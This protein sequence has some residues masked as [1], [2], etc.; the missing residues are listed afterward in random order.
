LIKNSFLIKC[1]HISGVIGFTVSI[2]TCGKIA[3]FYIKENMEQ[4]IRY[5]DVVV[6][7]AG[8]GGLTAGAILAKEGLDVVICESNTQAGGYLAGFCRGGFQF[9][10]SIQW[11]NQAIPGGILF[12]LWEYLG[13][14]APKCHS[15][16][17]IHRWVGPEHDYILTSNPIE[18]RDE[19]IKEFP[20]DKK[21]IL[22]FFKDAKKMAVHLKV[23]N[24]LMRT[25][26]NLSFFGKI[27]RGLIM[28]RHGL[29]MVPYIK[30]P[31]EKLLK[32]YFSTPK[33]RGIF[34]S[35]ESFAAV[36]FPVAC[37]FCDDFQAAPEGG[38][39]TIASWLS[40]VV[41]ENNG[42]V[43]L[44]IKV[45]K[46]LVNNSNTAY[47]VAL[48]DGTEIR[49]KYVI[50]AC[51]LFNLYKYML[52]MGAVAE[53]KIE[54]IGQADMYKSSFT[55]FLG[56]DCI[57][58]ELGFGEEVLHIVTDNPHRIDHASS[59]PYKTIIMV[60]AQSVR[61]KT[62]APE[63]KGTLMIHCPASME[64]GNYWKTSPKGVRGEDYNAFKEEFA[65]VL[66][67]RV[68]ARLAPDLKQHIV[69][70][71]IA[72]PLTYER[73]SLNYLGTIMGVKPNKA[74]IK[75]GLAHMKTPV[76]NL[77]IGG[78]CAEYSGGVPLAAKAGANAAAFILN[79]LNNPGFNKLKVILDS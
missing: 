23:M 72:T 36:I 40:G 41:S 7:G 48:P 19:L 3:L 28:T 57:S 24:S 2:L 44:G 42:E 26:P 16:K 47:G 76:K 45:L 63:G 75:A 8:S 54:Q 77:L 66:I 49:S 13:Q 62:L 71:N 37:A 64:Y 58:Q 33:L 5:S 35:Q 51:D 68:A 67:S 38:T 15:L 32:K 70:K 74:N 39:M 50:A 34:R 31:V 21:G 61:D 65:E 12:R 56:L 53:E 14:N 55:V 10:S 4:R 46:V 43:L 6:I 9:D 60:V 27:K 79:K 20:G 25:M 78:H 1:I 22:R 52:P 11:L 69:M 17:R 73:Y 18:L 30:I 59:D 29:P